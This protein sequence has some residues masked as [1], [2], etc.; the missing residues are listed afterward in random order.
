MARHIA[1]VSRSLGL[2][3]AEQVTV[4]LCRSFAEAGWRT[5]LVTLHDEP[6]FYPLPQGVGRVRLA[7]ERPSPN[8]LA[9]LVA[10]L[11]REYDSRK[12]IRRVFA[13]KGKASGRLTSR[14]DRVREP[15]SRRSGESR[16]FHRTNV[17]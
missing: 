4:F 3:G 2:G 9:G 11:G 17:C 5:T 16:D 1:I 8:R 13:R 12:R 10:K 15:T 14:P 7:L 6:D